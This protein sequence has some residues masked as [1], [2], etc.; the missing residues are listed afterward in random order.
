MT[1]L[2]DLTPDPARDRWL[3]MFAHDL[4]KPLCGVISSLHLLND[5]LQ[6]EETDEVDQ[7][8]RIAGECGQDMIRMIE[9][10]PLPTGD[11]SDEIYLADL[12]LSPLVDRI[13]VTL[14]SSARRTGVRILNLLPAGLPPVRVDE[15]RVTRLFI[16]LLDNAIRYAP[17]SE[18]RVEAIPEPVP[19]TG[20]QFLRIGVIDT[21]HGVP[22]EN[23]E[24]IFEL[25]FRAGGNDQFTRGYGLGLP[26]CRQTVELHGGKIWVESGPEGGAAF[27]FTLPIS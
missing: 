18:V 17:N 11:L 26:F 7:V 5:M 25:F 22:P 24:R 20:R 23:R 12:E 27:W 21:G 2:T 19:S 13:L 6:L 3:I 8:L 10:M 9:T 16:N 15:N 4:R 14:R 1:D